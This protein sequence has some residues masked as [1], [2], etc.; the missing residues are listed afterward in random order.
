MARIARP[1]P[2]G[3]FPR[4]T[5]LH[6][7][8]PI[9]I[10]LLGGFGLS[11][12]RERVS[13]PMNAERLVS[14]LALHGGPLQR[15]YVAGALWGDTTDRHASGSLRSAL[16]RLGSSEDILIETTGA[17]IELAAGVTVDHRECSALAQRI[18]DR[19]KDVSDD[20]LDEQALSAD[21]LPDWTDEWVLVEREA[22]HQLRLRAL[23]AM[24]DRL[25]GLGRFGQAVQAG[26]AAVAG[27]PL[28]ESARSV[29]ISA[30]L[31]ERNMGAALAEYESFR[32]LLRDDLHIEPS[33]RLQALVREQAER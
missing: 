31:A 2:V 4:A 3:R 29:L 32:T 6:R 9:R 1:P 18:L 20:D 24:C 21:I 7:S 23:E 12:G 22:F 10:G 25:T 15:T 28:R 16:W 30:H 33:E 13:L 8:A 11:V 26:L 27:E 5:V 17:H 19:S 14:F